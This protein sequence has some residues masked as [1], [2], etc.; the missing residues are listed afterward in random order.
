[1]RRTRP[2]PSW[3]RDL[4]M[5]VAAL[6]PAVPRQEQR[7]RGVHREREA[8][9]PGPGQ[10]GPEERQEAGRHHREDR[11]GRPQQVLQRDLLLQQPFVKDDKVSVE[12]HVAAVAKELGTTITVKGPT[13]ASRRA[14][15]LR[16]GRTTWLRKWRNSS[17]KG[18]TR[19][20]GGPPRKLPSIKIYGYPGLCPGLPIYF[21]RRTAARLRPYTYIYLSPRGKAPGRFCPPYAGGH[22]YLFFFGERTKGRAS[23]RPRNLFNPRAASGGTN[24]TTH[25]AGGRAGEATAQ[26]AGTSSRQERPGPHGAAPSAAPR[27]RRARRRR[28][29]TPA[30]RPRGASP[31]RGRNRH[32]QRHR[33][34]T[35]AGR[36]RAQAAPRGAPRRPR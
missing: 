32:G 28:F 26:K 1:M 4:A 35:G 34:K 18:I 2:S 9:P 8:R 31:G 29:A 13:P 22:S 20:T 21:A 3:G 24:A 33:G 12:Q 27:G 5:Q 25:S 30:T 6:N 7:L 11:H 16:R 15:A 36:A 19:G 14:R 17:N 10:G 23:A